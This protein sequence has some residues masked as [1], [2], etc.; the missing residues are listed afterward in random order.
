MLAEACWREVDWDCPTGGSAPGGAARAARESRSGTFFRA[1]PVAARTAPFYHATPGRRCALAP[2]HRFT[3][4]RRTKKRKETEKDTARVS[5]VQEGDGSSRRRKQTEGH[6]R[7]PKE[8]P[9]GDPKRSLPT[10]CYCARLA[11]CSQIPRGR[12]LTPLAASLERDLASL[13]P[14]LTPILAALRVVVRPCS[15]GTDAPCC[16]RN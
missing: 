8:T 6:G 10:S 1:A 3:P 7:K 13:S 9:E 4:N 5:R 12:L 16:R 2:Q 14:D 15:N 11:C